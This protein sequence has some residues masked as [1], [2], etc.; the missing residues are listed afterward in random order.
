MPPVKLTK[1]K[2]QIGS[3]NVFHLYNKLPDLTV[4]LNRP[5]PF[6]LFGLSETRLNSRVSDSAI[7]IPGYTVVRRDASVAGE[8]GLAVYIHD[9]IQPFVTRRLDLESSHVECI[10][11]ELKPSPQSPSVMVG[12]LYRNPAAGFDWYDDFKENLDNVGKRNS[13]FLLTGDFNID[14]LKPHPSWDATLSLFGLV[15]LVDIPTR[16]TASSSTL[17]DHVYT[18]KPS[19]VSDVSVPVLSVSDHYPVTCNWSIKLPKLKKNGHTTIVYR[20]FKHF[21]QSSFLFDLANTSF[22]S[23]FQET[24]PDSALSLW[25][26]L[27]LSVLDKHAPVR[28]K[29]VKH[30]TFP[31]W[32]TKEIIQAMEVRDDLRREKRFS[33]FKQQRNTVR[34][35]VRAA[36]KAYVNKVIGDSKDV[37]AVW[38]VVNSLTRGRNTRSAPIHSTLTADTFNDHFLSI[39]ESLLQSP[40]DKQEYVCP[41]RL[42]DFC[43]Q[44]TAS[45]IPFTI[46]SLAVHEVGSLISHM[47]NK[48][49]SG[50]DDINAQ[51][52]KLSIPYIVE[53][54]TYIF[55]LCIK[56][57]KFPSSLKTAKVIPLPKTK[58]LSDPNNYRPISLLSVISKPLERHV[59]KHLMKYLESNN[60]LHPFQSG[61][62]TKHSCHTALS[63]LSNAWLSNMNDSLITGAVFLDFKKAFDLVDHSTLLSKLHHYIPDSPSLPF[64]KSY[65]EDRKQKVLVNGS[66]S[67]KKLVKFGVPQG[68]ILGPLLFTIFINDL[69]LGLSGRETMCDLFADDTTIHAA[70][71][72][73]ARLS[74]RLQQSLCEVSAWCEDNAMIVH[75]VK[76]K[77]MVIAT[78][79]KHQTSSLSVN[80]SLGDKPVEQVTE[81]RVLGVIIDDKLTWKAHTISLSKVIS[82]KLFMLSKLKN[83]LDLDSRL[84][85]FNAQI[86]SHFDYASTVWDGC[87][88]NH[89]KKLVS[90]HRRAAKLILPDPLL[91]TDQKLDKI[92][93]LPLQKHLLYNKALV[94]YN[95]AH[96]ATPD[97]LC[98]L[99]RPSTSQYGS[100][101]SLFTVPFP[102]I[103]IYKSSLSFSGARLW[104]S[105]PTDVKRSPSIL[106]FKG[107]VRKFLFQATV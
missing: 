84:M 31:P 56:N 89:L 74:Q 60:L 76:T 92:E 29:R 70:D 13:N 38:R 102:R 71:K 40:R 27:F 82:R 55:N 46:P 41:Q 26:H 96:N 17:I 45:V 50:P 54:L 58:D 8:T 97:Y 63:R 4:F 98:Q 21:N 88:D 10:W 39:A 9:S 22:T 79:Q 104:N 86:R 24:D 6:H 87:S 47:K 57:N 106:S 52:L 43:R 11:L 25:C 34:Y 107:R 100:Q 67:S 99:F 59:H 14:M 15:Q 77:S 53:P 80:L 66:F 95:V 72:S 62:R 68:S 91:T 90:L 93:I 32:L 61:F 37:S 20:S 78:R 64:F 30:A 35:M 48:K 85:F 19:A 5:K 75:P 69:P 51:I 73:I 12:F 44:K 101:N 16:V 18:N 103:D 1:Q 3:L 36:Q 65:L 83:V 105:L 2:L 33:E 7:A 23:V 28:E 94:M 42:V 49:S 81:H